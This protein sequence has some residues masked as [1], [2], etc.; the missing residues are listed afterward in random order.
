MSS[1]AVRSAAL[2]TGIVP[3]FLVDDLDR[4]IAYYRDKLGFE[5]DF[6][7]DSFYASVSRNGCAIHLK[8]A[9]KLEAERAHRKEQEH[10]DAYVAVS[11]IRELFSELQRRGAEVLKPLEEQPWNCID[12]YVEDG[13]GYVLCFSELTA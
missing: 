9:P 4:A 3:Q 2:V 8:H 10:L 11:G 1:V 7:Y 6:V 13:D 12:F 5:V